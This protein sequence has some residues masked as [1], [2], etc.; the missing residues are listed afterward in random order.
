MLKQD[1]LIIGQG[2]AGSLLAWELSRRH[3]R[4]LI[5]DDAHQGSSSIIS[6]GIINPVTG[7]RLVI[8]EDYAIFFVQALKVYRELESLLTQRFFEPMD[9]MRI[10][11]NQEEQDYWQRR[12][13]TREGQPYFLSGHPPGTVHPA[14]KDPL[15][16]VRVTQSGFC[17]STRLLTALK[18]YFTDQNCLTRQRFTYDDVT[19]DEEGVRFGGDTFKA[20]IFCE[21]YQAQQNPWFAG[22]PFNSVKGEILHVDMAGSPLPRMMINKGKWCAPLDHQR[23]TAG[24]TYQ[25]DPLDSEPTTAGREQILA[26]LKQAFVNPVRVRDHKAGIRPVMK[27]QCAV[28]GRHPRCRQVGILNGLGSRGFLTAPTFAARL[29]DHLCHDTPIREEWALDRF[30]GQLREGMPR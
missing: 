13:D 15:G 10:F 2:V 4:V 18:S 16:S 5:V 6:A 12:M 22:L 27:D 25:W 8:Q 9:I 23:W 29:A 20:V 30:A 19:V 26:G 28:L 11:Q 1:Y 21:G 3:Q 24:A 14:L 7:K 17:H